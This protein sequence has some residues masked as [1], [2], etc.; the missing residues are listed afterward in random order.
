MRKINLIGISGKKGHGKDTLA[1]IINSISISN[2]AKS[3]EIRSFAYKLKEAVASNWGIKDS[4]VFE[5]RWF[6]DSMHPYLNITWRQLLQQYGEKMRE[7]DPDYWV[8]AL[9]KDFKYIPWLI[10]DVR[11]VNE[12]EH[13]RNI[14]GIIIRINRNLEEQKDNH[15]SENDLDNYDF[16]YVIDNNEHLDSLT[17][18]VKNLF[19]EI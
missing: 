18:K 13:I 15:L 4:S 12:A 3:F 1:K 5:E 7:I 19:K 8:K 10:S 9:F 17:V 16:D 11:Y 2:N 14:G 6:K